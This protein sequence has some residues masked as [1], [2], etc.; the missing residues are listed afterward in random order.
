MGRFYPATITPSKQEVIAGWL[1]S[2]PWAA[3]AGEIDVIGAY[4]IDDPDGQVGVEA[5]LVRAGGAILHV[6]LTYRNDPLEGAEAALV[7]TLEHSELGTRWVY[8]GLHDPVCTM[9]LAATAMTGQGEALGM[10]IRD[11]RWFLAPSPVRIHGGGWGLERIFVDGLALDRDGAD[12]SV[13]RNDRIELTVHRRPQPGDQPPIG[14]TA[15][16]EG[17]AQPVVLATVR[18]LLA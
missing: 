17:Q 3:G 11:G 14:L 7:G 8:D 1:P 10:G 5:H 12:G 9:V 2:Q 16:W 15:S 6:P 4:R 18:D 13:L